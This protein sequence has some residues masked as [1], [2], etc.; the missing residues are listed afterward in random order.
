MRKELTTRG[1]ILGALITTIF[2]A[3]NVYL[4]LKVGQV[5]DMRRDPL[6]PRII[7]VEMRVEE[8]T[9]IREGTTAIIRR[10]FL[11]GSADI[12]LSPG[13]G[14]ELPSGGEILF[15]ETTLMR[16]ESS[17][18]E[19]LEALAGT[20]TAVGDF[21]ATNRE[22]THAL[23]GNGDGCQAAGSMPVKGRREP[24]SVYRV[25]MQDPVNTSQDD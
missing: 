23:L 6:D 1:L 14:A 21:F 16:F 18:P 22:A 24:V 8:D 20:A 13:S 9:S 11:T 25:G 7:V 5:H 17:L 4:G 2:T 19:T 10:N 12:E 15:E 3:A